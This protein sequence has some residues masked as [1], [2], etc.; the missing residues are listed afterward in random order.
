MVTGFGKNARNIL[1]ALHKDPDIEVVEAAN[2]VRFGADLMTPWETYGT[3]PINPN[4]LQAIQGDP[5]KERMASYGLY[6]IDEIIN[7]CKP[8][9]YLRIEDIWAFGDY[10]KKPWWNKINK[11]LWTTLDSVPILDQALQMEPLCDKML[12]WASF[13]EKAMKELGHENVETLHGAVDYTNF[14]PLENRNEIRERLNL[15]D[16]FVIG[17]VFKNQLRKSVPNLLQ[18]FKKFKKDYPDTKAKLLLHTN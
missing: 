5:P 15:K 13:A 3:G 18:G 14:K 16:D 12:V 10:H 17:F 11:V 6:T 2:G 1:L 8:D 9:I 4:L 7:K